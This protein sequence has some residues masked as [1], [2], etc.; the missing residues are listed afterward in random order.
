[1][2]Y[3]DGNRG[4]SADQPA[5]SEIVGNDSQIA[6]AKK[7]LPGLAAI[8][9]ESNNA[10]LGSAQSS[11]VLKDRFGR[12]HQ[13]LRISVTDV[14]NIRCQY[15]MPAE[16]AQFLASERLLSFEQIEEFVRVA[17]SFGIRRIRLTG[18]EPLSRPNLHQLVAKLSAIDGVDDLAL[19]TNGTLL[20]PQLPGLVRAGLRRINLSLD[21]LSATT[22][23]HISRRKSFQNVLEGLQAALKCPDVEV[24]LNTLV[25]RHLNMCEVIDLVTYAREHQVDI[26]FIEFMPLDASRQ[27]QN[28]SVVTG[29]ELREIIS[30]RFGPLNRLV[31]QRSSQPSA[32]YELSDG[33]LKIGFIDSVSQPFCGACDRLRL[34]A[35]GQLQNCL[36]GTE[37]WPVV[38][39]LQ[40]LPPDRESIGALLQ[41]C[42]SAKHPAHGISDPQFVAPPRAM[43]Q[44][45]G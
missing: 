18:G 19:T 38:Q 40:T 17:V 44:I 23:E 7:M 2:H 6:D 27:W 35:D 3:V 39:L 28:S 31:D 41:A 8:S 42:V 10:Q 20:A 43:Y 12:I 21:T 32:D 15:C 37:H 4:A 16:G 24:K 13:S 36:F 1:M 26:R 30:R 9:S 29:H 34:T 5:S 11:T 22:F 45:G 25:L 33:S 14:C